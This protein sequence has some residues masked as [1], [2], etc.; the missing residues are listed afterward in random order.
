MKHLFTLF[1]FFTFLHSSFT[2][3]DFYDINRYGDISGLEP[4]FHGVASGDP[5][6]NSVILWTRVATDSMEA[7]V[8]WHIARDTGMTDIVAEGWT[9]T[10][11]TLDF[12]VKVDVTGL[13]PYTTYYY[14][15]FSHDKYSLRGRTKTAPSTTVDALRFGVV[16]CSNFAHGFF[17]VYEKLVDRNDI[18]A[19]IH[20]GDYIYEY[21]DGEYGDVREYEPSTEILN[22]SDYRMRHSYYKLDPMLRRLHQQYAIIATW[23]DHESANNSWDDGA[24]N[25]N[26]GEGDW[27]T[28]KSA[29]IQAYDEWMPFRKPDATDEERIYRKL[30]YG[31]LMD[32]FMLDTRLIGRE[33]QG[34]NESDPNRTILG[35]D[36]YNWL[37]TEMGNSTAK[38][39][40]LGQQVMM[41][42]LEIFGNPVN[43]DQWDGY[44]AER[45]KLQDFVINNN[46]PNMVILTGDIHTS[47]AN[48]I[49]LD[50]YDE[51]TGANSAGVEFVVTSVTSPSF[52]FGGVE[53]LITTF[54]P[55]MK[56]IDLVQKGYYILDVTENR[57]Q[58]DWFYIDDVQS[59]SANES[60]GAS[61]YTDDGTRHLNNSPNPTVA[62][63]SIETIYA[64]TDPRPFETMVGNEDLNE[65]A[66]IGVHPNPVSENIYLQFFN[67][68]GHEM[69]LEI[70]D[71]LGKLV[72]QEDLGFRAAGLQ[73]KTVPVSSLTAGTY[74]VILNTEKGNYRKSI[75]KVKQ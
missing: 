40:V 11:G 21:G 72:I 37:T 46:V 47:W 19:I 67:Y 32:L 74:F 15:F 34:Q 48:D 16:S 18:D 64:P 70:Y 49:P 43:D 5:T 29:S 13:D 28:R 55:H 58:A 24:E 52:P 39:Q 68:E 33:E 6:D 27:A 9:T 45:E 2:Q 35:A 75:L 54:N 4:F 25:H 61:W 20:L 38:W 41:A 53:N 59:Q 65:L 66:F 57:C 42:P 3:I 36:Q 30:S 62:D 31:G 50:N 71:A 14:D 1:L 63:I 51:N 69:T 7:H 60:H 8:K 10:D 17:N 12:T 23:D 22:I 26:A 73:N 44:P 56:F